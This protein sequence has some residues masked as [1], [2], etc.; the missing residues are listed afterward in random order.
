MDSI[1]IAVIT[2]GAIA[3]TN[4]VLRYDTA[5]VTAAIGCITTCLSVNKYLNTKEGAPTK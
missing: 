4:M 1:D 5:I 2:L 3:L